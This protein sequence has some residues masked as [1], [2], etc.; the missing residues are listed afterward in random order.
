MIIRDWRDAHP[1]DMQRLYAREQAYWIGELGWDAASVW[2]D[3]EHAR[4]G[5]GLEGR[6][7]V[8]D[9]GT[10]RGWAYCLTE[11]DTAHLGGVVADTSPA[12]AVL[13]G[14]CLDIAR[15]AS[16]SV[17]VSSFGPD[18]AAG[19]ES[20]LKE[21]GFQ[22][23]TYHYMRRPLGA[24]RTDGVPAGGWSEAD[25]RPA[26]RLFS[27]AY[28]AHG[29]HFAPHG[30]AEEWEQYARTLVERAACGV[31]EPAA[32]RVVRGAD[33]LEALVLA[34]RVSPDT[35]HLAQ[36]AVHPARRREGL[37]R[38]LVEEACGAGATSGARQATLLVGSHNH[39]ARS[40]YASMGFE[41]HA[42]FLAGILDA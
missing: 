40:L 5:R 8:D 41:D 1:P 22:C 34:T 29:R 42:T 17:C 32:S 10:I 9:D 26:A 18:R 4:L 37:A 12:T 23:E 33:R 14:A 20:V 3:L 6:L 30:T 7:A 35:V 36:V 2:Q 16:R 28:G 19:F 25:V 24:S 39:A 15:G 38:R 13:V 11:G 21:R 27:E 31:L